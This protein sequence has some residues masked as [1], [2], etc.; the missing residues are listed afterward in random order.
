MMQVR[1]MR[2]VLKPMAAALAVAATL[3]LASAPA[4]A[5]MPASRLGER[6]PLQIVPVEDLYPWNDLRWR[7]RLYG[8]PYP[9]PYFYQHVCGFE[10]MPYGVGKKLRWRT[11]YRCH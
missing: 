9:Y 7:R 10:R 6:A 5:A 2:T 8:I 11:V 1:S 4:R 3:A